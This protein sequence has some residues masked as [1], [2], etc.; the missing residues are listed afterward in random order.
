MASWDDVVAAGRRLPEVVESTWYRTRALKVGGAGMCRLRSDP[1]ALVVRVVDLADK[2]ALLAQDPAVFF[3]TPHY[4]GHPLVLVRL[5][6][7]DLGTLGELIEDA[8][9]T[10]AP[11]RLVAAHDAARRSDG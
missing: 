10:V 6:A 8:W 5:E 2:E 7:V 1:D 9:R 4:D 11:P 3:T